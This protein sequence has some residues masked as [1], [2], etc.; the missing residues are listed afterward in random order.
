MDGRGPLIAGTRSHSIIACAIVSYAR[1]AGRLE[2]TLPPF[3][4]VRVHRA[5]NGDGRQHESPYPLLDG[6]ASVE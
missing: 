1:V 6:N 3:S 2:P 4:S 5:K